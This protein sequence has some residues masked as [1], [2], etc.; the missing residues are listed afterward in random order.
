MLA[1]A[2]SSLAVLWDFSCSVKS[3]AAPMARPSTAVIQTFMLLGLKSCPEFVLA[4]SSSRSHRDYLFICQRSQHGG[5]LSAGDPTTTTTHLICAS[6]LHVQVRGE[7]VRLFYKVLALLKFWVEAHD[8]LKSD[9][10]VGP[11]F[12]GTRAEDQPSES[13]V[14]WKYRSCFE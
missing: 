7:D 4:G 2:P 3:A 11:S 8:F 6:V 12:W 14:F 10:V 1:R 13:S 5:R 9:D